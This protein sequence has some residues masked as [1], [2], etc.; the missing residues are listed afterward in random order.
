MQS[1]AKKV[2]GFTLIEIMIVIG[3]IG[4]IGSIVMPAANAGRDKA[5]IAAAQTELNSIKTAF[6]QLYTDTG[7][8]PNGAASYCRSSLPAD[9]E[10]NL[11]SS[12]SNLSTD[13]SGWGGWEG[14]YIS[15]LTDPWSTPYYLDEDYQCL[16]TTTGCNGLAD[17]GTDSSVLVSCG[18]NREV[19]GGSCTYDGD[20]IVLRLCD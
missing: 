11:A 14:P 7:L 9:N 12:T 16:A 2:R 17:S 5:L 8:Y 6:E 18:P 13:D 19:S 15:E 20:N 4:V 10:V 3:I 1:E